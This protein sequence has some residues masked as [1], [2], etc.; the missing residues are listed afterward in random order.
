[1]SLKN[2]LWVMT[3]SLTFFQCC[4]SQEFA[5][6]ENWLGEIEGAPYEFVHHQYKHYTK[7]DIVKAKQILSSIRNSSPKDE[8]EGVYSREVNLH[9][10]KLFWRA[11]VGFI[12]YNI[13]TCAIELRNLNYG[14]INDSPSFIELIS[15]KPITLAKN[16]PKAENKLVKVKFG[17]RHFLVPENRLQDFAERTVG[18]SNELEDY[19]YYWRKVEDYEK[20]VFGLPILPL[21]YKHLLRYPKEAEIIGIRNRKIHQEKAFDGTVGY[22]EVHYFVILRAGNNKNIKIGMNFFVED[23]GEWIEITKVSS[24]NPVGKIIRG[25]NENKQEECQ[26]EEH[27]QGKVIPCKEIKIGMKAK[28]RLIEMFF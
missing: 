27:F 23:L 10:V 6:E 2:F 8:W 16:I 26:N 5:R 3:I 17:A 4:F 14:K 18:L 1:M 28:T 21:E 9:D 20:E 24:K 12:N 19:S 11:N 13:Y 25:F 7:E 15:E 22:E